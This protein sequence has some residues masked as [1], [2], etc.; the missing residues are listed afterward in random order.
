MGKT[1]IVG[2]GNLLLGDDGFGVRVLQ[3]LERTELPLNVESI[4]VGIGGMDLIYRLMER[5]D[6][7]IVV[8]AARFGQVPGTL[9]IFRPLRPQPGNRERPVEPHL[10][11]PARA[12]SVARQLDI[13]PENVLVVG[14][15]PASCEPGLE[16]SPAVAGAV[17]EAVRQIRK[18][19]GCPSTT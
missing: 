9:K 7:L 13:L 3:E 4:E 16:L 14:C 2:F 11:E 12:M 19:V 17:V 6:R 15:Q 10:T 18:L 8:D 5:F 1:L